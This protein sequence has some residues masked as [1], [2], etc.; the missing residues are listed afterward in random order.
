MYSAVHDDYAN[1]KENEEENTKREGAKRGR[2]GPDALGQSERGAAVGC[3]TDD[4]GG[5][6]SVSG[7]DDLE[8]LSGQRPVCGDAVGMES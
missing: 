7:G 2:G 6:A 3:R 1:K 4:R 5:A 8:I